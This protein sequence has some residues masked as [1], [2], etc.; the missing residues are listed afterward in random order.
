MLQGL[1]SDG[2]YKLSTGCSRQINSLQKASISLLHTDIFVDCSRDVGIVDNDSGSYNSNDL[3]S[4]SVFSASTDNVVLW[5]RRL[6]PTSKVDEL[7]DS[8]PVSKFASKLLV[9][10]RRLKPS[11]NTGL[12][13]STSQAD[14]CLHQTDKSQ[15]D[16]FDEQ[17][18]MSQPQVSVSQN[19]V[20][21]T[22]S[23]KQDIPH[24]REASSPS[25]IT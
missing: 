16:G 12:V 6:G 10:Q 21:T 8:Q 4:G 13:S 5:R 23:P 14:M 24:V 3:A 7:F 1:E 18:N 11:L 20:Q 9:Y 25:A 17:P 22:F 19:S 2:L 15:L